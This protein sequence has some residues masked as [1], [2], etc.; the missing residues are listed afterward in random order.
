MRMKWTSWLMKTMVPSKPERAAM[1][2]SM[3]AMSRG[4]W[5][6][7]RGGGSWG[8]EEELAEGEAAFFP[9]AED[10]DGFV[11]VFAGE[12]E[13]AEEGADELLG[14]AVFDVHG[15][16]EDGALG[17]EHFDAVLGEVAPAVDVVAHGAGAL[18]DGEDAGED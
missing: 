4:G 9:A 6:A 13:G 14:L 12:E 5:W 11:H 17:L 2:A 1:R 18:L 10:G 8:I 16:L 7:R 3:L 15:F